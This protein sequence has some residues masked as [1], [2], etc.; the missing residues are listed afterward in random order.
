MGKLATASAASISGHSFAAPRGDGSRKAFGLGSRIA[1]GVLLTAALFGGVG[2]WTLTAK[3]AGAVITPGTVVVDENLKQVQHLDGG[4]VSEIAVK[5]GDEVEA[6]QILLRIDDAQTRAELSIVL[7]QTSELSA[8]RARL[9]AESAGASEIAFPPDSQNTPEKR[10]FMEGE[11]RL[12]NGQRASRESQKQQLQLG[13]DQIGGE[14]DGLTSQRSA[15]AEEIAL[16][17]TENTRTDLLSQ[18]GLIETTRLHTIRREAIRLRG[19]LGEIDAQLARAHTRISEIGLQILSIDQNAQNEAQRQ[20]S[21][22]D[23]RLQELAERSLASSDRLSRTDIRAPI[24]GTVNELHIHTLGG[25]VTPAEVLVTIVPAGSKL[26]VA[27]RISPMSIEQVSVGL[28]A[29]L[30]FS[31]FNQRTTPELRGQVSHV[32]PATTDDPVTGER[33]YQGHVEIFAEELA[34]LGESALLPGMPVEVFVQTE[35]RTV[36]SYLARPVIDQ[37]NRAFRER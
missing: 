17:E 20:L 16:V 21:D 23:A 11:L 3:I 4:I 32:S 19:E 5:E 33:Y 14:I 15:K 24:S 12:F 36:A 1:V 28:P 30:R 8:R 31:A 7:S 27:I 37:F 18:R 25:V 6:G 35:E 2:G 22:V 10:A 34:S 9:L 13:I 26:K 29:R